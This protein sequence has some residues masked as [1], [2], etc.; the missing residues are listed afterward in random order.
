MS[1]TLQ[2]LADRLGATVG[3]DGTAAVAGCAPIQVAGPD[4]ITFLANRKYAR[5]LETTRAAAVLVDPGTT[6]PG[7]LARLVID[8]P[9]FAFRNARWGHP[10]FPDED[11][12]EMLKY[13]A[14]QFTKHGLKTKPLLCD[15]GM[16]HNFRW[17]ARM[18]G[19]AELLKCVG[20][21]GLQIA[22]PAEP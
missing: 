4:E 15:T 12:P 21:I 10:S 11:Y 18:L 19:D 2:E 17:Y 1:M 20:G 3:G 16:P 8:D 22:W 9:Y 5:F 14:G 13:L 6:C 7:H